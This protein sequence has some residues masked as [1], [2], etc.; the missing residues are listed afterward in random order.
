[1]CILASLSLVVLKHAVD[2]VFLL[3]SPVL[4]IKLYSFDVSDSMVLQDLLKRV[5]STKTVYGDA[6]LAMRDKLLLIYGEAL[7]SNCTNL[8]QMI[9]VVLLFFSIK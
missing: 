6:W 5:L 7:S 1:M 9:Q 8:V 2:I 3:S 4:D